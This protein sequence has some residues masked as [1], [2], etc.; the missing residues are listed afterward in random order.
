VLKTTPTTG[1]VLI[2]NIHSWSC[3]GS[4][5]KSRIL[6]GVNSGTPN[7]THLFC[8]RSRFVSEIILFIYFLYCSFNLLSS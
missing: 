6:A 3:S 8:K 7:P 2:K 5:C 4:C 1:S